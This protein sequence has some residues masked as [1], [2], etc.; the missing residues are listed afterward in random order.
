MDI[1][2]TSINDNLQAYII[3]ITLFDPARETENDERL[4]LASFIDLYRDLPSYRSDN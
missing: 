4:M 2:K 3:G 1:F